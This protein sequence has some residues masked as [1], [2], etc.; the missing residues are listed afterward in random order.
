MYK[1]GEETSNSLVSLLLAIIG[2]AILLIPLIW[3]FNYFFTDK[4]LRNA[5]DLSEII[6]NNLESISFNEGKITLQ[7][8]EGWYLFAWGVDDSTNDGKPGSCFGKSCI[9]V[10]EAYDSC[11]GNRGFCN[12]LDFEDV[13][14]E[15]SFTYSEGN[16][17]FVKTY[18][19][20]ANCYPFIKKS[21]VSDLPYKVELNGD[22]S[23][24]VIS[25]NLGYIDSRL[26]EKSD[27]V[28]KCKYSSSDDGGKIIGNPGLP[29]V[30]EFKG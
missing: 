16:A 13:S 18:Y 8:I 12:N 15:S 6:S 7:G 14:V 19:V 23:N 29:K 11:E 4:D 25:Q 21:L 2:I 5:K 10:C 24:L 9:C 20:D 26:Y 27:I 28:K 3:A 17:D 30:G 22:S 1:K